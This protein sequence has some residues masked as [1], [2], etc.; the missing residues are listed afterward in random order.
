[1]QR[2]WEAYL[3]LSMVHGMAFPACASGEGP[4]VETVTQL[5]RDD[6][7]GAIEIGW[8]KDPAVR[9][10]VRAIAEQARLKLG[11]AAQPTLLGPKLSLNDLDDVGRA[12][13]GRHRGAIDEAVEWPA[14]AAFLAAP[15]PAMLSASAPS[16]CGRL[17]VH[18]VRLWRGAASA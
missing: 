17:A 11:Y 6:F 10:R 16:T 9:Q 1:M 2:P 12:R 5:A 13:G 3:T 15:T 8:I 4:F 18:T 14:R 7:F